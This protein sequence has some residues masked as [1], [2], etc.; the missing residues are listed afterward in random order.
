MRAKPSTAVVIERQEQREIWATT[1]ARA[2]S[3][4]ATELLGHLGTIELCFSEVRQTAGDV[5]AGHHLARRLNWGVEAIEAIYTTVKRHVR[6]AELPA[7]SFIDINCDA[8]LEAALQHCQPLMRERRVVCQRHE[9]AAIQCRGDQ[10]LLLCALMRILLVGMSAYAEQQTLDLALCE[11]DG[12][13]RAD[14]LFQ[15]VV[16]EK[17][18]NTAVWHESSFFED[19][20]LMQ[21]HQIFELHRGGVLWTRELSTT[22][23]V[24]V[25]A[26]DPT[27]VPETNQGGACIAM[28]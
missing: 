17:S 18:T 26:K 19:S 16:A 22:R 10:S 4:L 2:I 28:G 8:L 21:L 20:G 9:N 27:R 15:G 3:S 13:V 11:E 23:C 24:A 5:T 7:A 25:W 14:F 1:T 12:F 6:Q